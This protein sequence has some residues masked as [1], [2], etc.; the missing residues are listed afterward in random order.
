MD[1]YIYRVVRYIVIITI[2]IYIV[3]YIVIITIYIYI[4]IYIAIG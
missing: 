2:Y 1:I 3:I 4:V